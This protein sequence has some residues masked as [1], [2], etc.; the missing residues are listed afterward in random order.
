M[1]T[2]SYIIFY[3]NYIPKIGVVKDVYLDYPPPPEL[4]IIPYYS[5]P[6]GVVLGAADGHAESGFPSGTVSLDY[7]DL[8][9]NQ[10]Y[11]VI[12]EM[13]L[14]TSPSNRDIGNFMV[15]LELWSPPTTTSQTTPP[16]ERNS[17]PLPTS[18]LLHR[19]LRPVILTYH[20]PLPS[21]LSTLLRAPLLLLSIA[22]E[23]EFIAIP[24][25]SRVS[26]PTRSHTP[27]SVKLTLRAPRVQTYK[28]QVKFKARLGGLRHIMY[29]YRL[30]AAVTFISGFWAIEIVCAM[31]VWWILIASRTG[32]GLLPAVATPT[33]I[34][35]DQKPSTEEEEEEE[36]HLLVESEPTRERTTPRESGPGRGYLPSPSPTPQ[37][38]PVTVREGYAVGEDI[39]TEGSGAGGE[40][41]RV[42]AMSVELETETEEEAGNGSEE[43]AVIVSQQPGPADSGIGSSIYEQ[44]DRGSASSTGAQRGSTGVVEGMRKR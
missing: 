39:E 29:N 25:L 5:P 37:P 13:H 4:S 14:P 23:Q 35:P 44:H 11:D 22:K 10:D 17:L 36:E 9:P 3:L 43:E 18:N 19:S 38:E 30:A 2:I 12:V 1:S 20:S 6:G 24:L 26:F 8:I 16:T 15:D 41:P 42:R 28:I 31:G 32:G 21:F 27:S 7:Q 33:P 40:R 34:G